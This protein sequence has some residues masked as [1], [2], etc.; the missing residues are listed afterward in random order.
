MSLTANEKPAYLQ[1]VGDSNILWLVD[2]IVVTGTTLYLA[3]NSDDVS[4]DGHTYTGDA[5]EIGALRF[6]AGGRLEQ[7][8]IGLANVDRVL[9]DHIESNDDYIVGQRVTL[10]RVLADHLADTTSQQVFPLKVAE[11]ESSADQAALILHCAHDGLETKR[12]PTS[13]ATQR[14]RWV[15]KGLECGYS[16]ATSSCNKRLADCQAMNGGSNQ[17]RFGGF[18]HI[19]NK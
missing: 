13:R 15:F 17:A 19:P 3:A 11:A 7:V 5:I 9:T 14:C 12:F 8:D 10:R 1:P 18:P 16:G 4:F 2:L 6:N